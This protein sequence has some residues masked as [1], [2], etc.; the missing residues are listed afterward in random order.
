[1]VSGKQQK[2][3]VRI[4]AACSVLQH[5]LQV[6]P[7]LSQQVYLGKRAVDRRYVITVPYFTF[8]EFLRV[9]VISRLD[10]SKLHCLASSKQKKGLVGSQVSR[11]TRHQVQLGLKS[12]L[13]QRREA[14]MAWRY[15]RQSRSQSFVTLD[16]RSENESSGSIHFEITMANSRVPVIR[17]IA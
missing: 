14:P 15:A 10:L 5:H 6:V 12:N 16:Q 11:S 8:I 17:L 7:D 13:I 1:L 9:H 2:D 4:P 3:L